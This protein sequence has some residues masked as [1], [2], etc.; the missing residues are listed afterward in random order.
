MAD[1]K[2]EIILAA[3]DASEAAFRQV[4][5]RV[6][7]LSTSVFSLKGALAGI[8]VGIGFASIAKSVLDTASSFEKLT[9]RLDTVTKGRGRETLAL[10]DATVKDLPVD[11][12]KATDA[13]V[14]M[15]AMGLTPTAEKLRTLVDV[16][17]VLGEEAMPRVA[18]A[19]G[20]MA[21]LGKLSAEELNQ[22]SEVGI[23]ARKYLAE[24]FGMT[25]DELQKSSVG[26]QS[27]IDTIWRG[28]DAD[29][30]G[31][32]K[33]AMNSWDGL[34]VQFRKSIQDLER[35]IADAGIFDALKDGMGTVNR[36]LGEWIK[37][38]ETFLKQDLPRHIKEAT[39]ALREFLDLARMPSM[40]GM[41]FEGQQLINKGLIDSQKFYYASHLERFR[42][43]EEARKLDTGPVI[44]GKLPPVPVPAAIPAGYRAG[45]G[46]TEPDQGAAKRAKEAAEEAAKASKKAMQEYL[47]S[48]TGQ[49]SYGAW[50]DDYNSLEALR[51]SL[52]KYRTE[53]K[54]FDMDKYKQAVEDDVRRAEK[55]IPFLQKNGID[56]EINDVVESAN[57]GFDAMVELSQHTA[58]RMQDNF[59][60]FFFDAFRGELKSFEDYANAVMTSIQR[61]M[62]D[63][64]GQMATQA[65]F[66]AKSV[67]GTQG[68]GGLVGWLAGLIGETAAASA[69]LSTDRSCSRSAT[70]LAWPARLV[71]RASSRSNACRLED[72][73]SSRQAAP[74][75]T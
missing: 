52:A 65:I 27:I 44:R 17:S 39:A 8:G 32:A 12:S 18:R 46:V 40:T 56:S 41:V 72:W 11:V 55:E 34:M 5:A 71:R 59:S 45:L 51:E 4:N 50:E 23:N 20:Q 6:R 33:K 68:G 29:Y 28:L 73:G 60:D 69:T 57:T 10:I 19:L 14:M 2:L 63:M 13:W 36:S 48:S 66:G 35:Q 43:I 62:A 9:L 26:I 58:E 53:I 16:S 64:A 75:P 30:A 22:L 74:R 67:G 49:I 1:S 38:N 7:E 70:A 21:S 61:A 47:S 25:V 15:G 31:G 42:M 24:G 37:N 3:K 54:Q